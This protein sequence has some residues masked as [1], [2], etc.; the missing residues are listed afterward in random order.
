MNYRK[1]KYGKDIS[2]LGYGCMRFS[3]TAGKIDRK[4]AEKIFEKYPIKHTPAQWALRWLW[5]QP[6]VTCVLSGM[7]SKEMV[8]DNIK[9]AS[10]V[11]VGEIG[12][13]EEAM[14]QKIV[15]AINAKMKVGCT[16]CAYCM[17]CPKNVDIS[18]TFAA[19]NR[20]YSDGK[21][22]A[23]MEYFMCTAL[24]K[25]S[26]AASNCVECGKCEKHC[27]QHIKIR[28]EL[29]NA[30]KQLEN[31]VYKIGRKVVELLKLY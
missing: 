11:S 30:R 6:E 12:A 28:K 4:K 19:Y 14:L 2:I 3:K 1:D 9:T 10:T 23:L 22:A 31:P 25:N 18:G 26:S 21:R 8:Q 15:Q 16:G 29:K 17:P 20:C 5:N 13:K 7:N 24:R 27:P